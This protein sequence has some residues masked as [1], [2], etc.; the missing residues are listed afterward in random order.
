MPSFRVANYN[1]DEVVISFG[2][3]LINS[4]YADGE[5]LTIEMDSDTSVDVAGTDGE[6]CVSRTNDRR[7][8]ITV[9]LLQSSK[10]NDQLSALY[11]LFV[12]NYSSGGGIV[13]LMIKDLNGNSVYTAAHAWISKPPDV[14]YD[15][16]ATSREWTIRVAHLV[17]TD[18]QNF[19]QIPGA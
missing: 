12:N 1:A 19:D 10:I 6:V 9:K 13:P 3:V 11:N 2:S 16:S 4:G 7:A 17:R 8:T 14:S 5:F 15:R 18:G